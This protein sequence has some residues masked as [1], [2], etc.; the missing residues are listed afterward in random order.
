MAEAVSSADETFSAKK[1]KQPCKSA[2]QSRPAN[3][4]IISQ[5]LLGSHTLLVRNQ[6]TDA[7][8]KLKG[9]RGVDILD[10]FVRGGQTAS[11]NTTPDGTYR[12]Q[13]AIGD[14]YLPACVK[15]SR[16]MVAFEDPSNTQ[17]ATSRSATHIITTQV[18]Y[19]LYRVPGGNLQVR[20]ISAE[21]F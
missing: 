6:S 4:R 12:F 17:F 11:I 3:G 13:Y 14:G 19:T 10:L 15:F 20:E 1:R 2:R 21:S 18:E 16:N 8:I 9:Y 5:S 7:L